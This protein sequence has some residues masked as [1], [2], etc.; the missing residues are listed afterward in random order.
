MEDISTLPAA[1]AVHRQHHVLGRGSKSTR[2]S[3]RNYIIRAAAKRYAQ[4]NPDSSTP[5]LSCAQLGVDCS[6]RRVRELSPHAVGKPCDPANHRQHLHKTLAFYYDTHHGSPLALNSKPPGSG[7]KGIAWSVDEGRDLARSDVPLP[8]DGSRVRHPTLE[9]EE[10]FRDASTSK[11]NVRLR[12]A[13]PLIPGDEDAQIAELYR[14]GLLYDDQDAPSPAFDLNSIPHEEPVYSIRPA[15]RARKL[16]RAR[17]HEPLPLNLSFTD[18]GSDGNISQYLVSAAPETSP[19]AD[20]ARPIR[21]HS[22]HSSAGSAPLRVIYEL[23]S[24]QPSFDVDTSQLPDLVDDL[25][26]DYDCFSESELDDVPSQREVHDSG[27]AAHPPSDAWVILGD[28][29]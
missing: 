21:H 5:P 24:A 9:R 13:I 11:G 17:A 20:A 10:A 1:P 29:L 2:R 6:D 25:L 14:M 26:S 28:D 23:E 8:S 12:P 16:N 18:L 15:K 4:S 22:R 7:R 27:G 19:H 3:T